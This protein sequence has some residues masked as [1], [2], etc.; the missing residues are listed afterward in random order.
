[1]N[2]HECW[3]T[4]REEF[5][6][7]D[8]KALTFGRNHTQGLLKND[9]H[10]WKAVSR[11]GMLEVVGTRRVDIHSRLADPTTKISSDKETCLLLSDESQENLSR[12]GAPLRRMAYFRQKL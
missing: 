12:N 11:V 5:S 1:M 10:P 9:F 4:G 3:G 8:A 2:W 7:G 6:R